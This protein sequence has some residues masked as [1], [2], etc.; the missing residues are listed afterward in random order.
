LNPTQVIPSH[1]VNYS[2]SPNALDFVKNY[3]EN[4]K[5]AVDKSENSVG[6]TQFMTTQYPN[7]AGKNEL[8]MG[9]KVFLGEMDW[10]LRSPFPAIGKKIELDFG[11]NRLIVNMKDHKTINFIGENGERSL[12]YSVV[13]VAKN[14]FMIDWFDP[15]TKVNVVSIQDYNKNI[16]YSDILKSNGSSEHLKGKIKFLE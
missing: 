5:K 6:I 7:L 12:Q 14:I 9:A 10:D 16:A 3:L 1:F 8:E 11:T 15:K 4:Y 13:E 2:L